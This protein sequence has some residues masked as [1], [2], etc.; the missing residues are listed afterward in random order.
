M[1]GYAKTISTR[2]GAR[3]DDNFIIEQADEAQM[4]NGNRGGGYSEYTSENRRRFNE[5]HSRT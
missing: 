5:D 4:G 1:G 3:T 2:A